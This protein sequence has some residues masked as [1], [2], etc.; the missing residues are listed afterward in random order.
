MLYRNAKLA[1]LEWLQLQTF[2]SENCSGNLRNSKCHLWLK[3]AAVK[4][5]ITISN[6]FYYVG[7]T[8]DVQWRNREKWIDKEYLEKVSFSFIQL[9]FGMV[10]FLFL[11]FLESIFF[12][13]YVS[14]YVQT[15]R[16]GK[17]VYN[18]ETVS[19]IWVLSK[20]TFSQNFWILTLHHHIFVFVRSG[21]RPPLYLKY[22]C[23]SR[24]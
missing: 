14:C 9:S 7:N 4:L 5:I 1:T 2:S 8:P 21:Q 13:S 11:F 3:V 19:C 16:K 10:V 20:N 24:P 22:K 15:N 18:W 17:T 12:T 23:V 6:L